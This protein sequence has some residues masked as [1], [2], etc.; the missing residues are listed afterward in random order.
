MKT[1]IFLAIM[2]SS[3]LLVHTVSA[4]VPMGGLVVTIKPEKSPLESNEIPVLVGTVTDQASRP[5]ANAQVNISTAYG[6]FQISTDN[7]GKFRYQ[8]QNPVAPAQYLV[9]V[10]AQKDGYGIGLAS[11]TFFVNGVPVSQ[12]QQYNSNSVSGNNI[13]QDPIAS[14]ILK[15]AE[16]AKKQQAEQNAKIKQI[17]EEKK[18]VESQRALANQQ[19]QIDLGSWFAQF[20]PFTPRN[21]YA[22]FVSQINQSVQTIFWGQFNFTEQKTNEGLAA[23]DQ[24]L[25]NGGT[26]DQARN[27]F[28]QNA[29]SSKSE[30]T[31]LNND[32]NVKYG[33]ASNDAQAKFDKYGNLPRS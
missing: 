19:L 18:F 22:E 31:H 33:N 10:K 30:I 13:S 9:N 23:R 15:N 14:K 3:V 29:S 28:I 4:I 7:D 11:T 20:N 5:I 16:L 1:A 8:Y 2:I 24:V 26:N 6:T 32:L 12:S 21:A 25:Q 27:A 17:E